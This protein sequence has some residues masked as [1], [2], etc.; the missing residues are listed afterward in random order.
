MTID[1]ATTTAPRTLRLSIGGDPLVADLYEPPQPTGE[2][3]VLLVHGWGGSGRY[4]AKTVQ[5]LRERFPLIVPDMPGIGRAMPVRRAHDMF[6][7]VA[8]L[9]ALCNELGIRKAHV[10]GH[11]M[12]GGVTIMLAARRPDLIER[13][14][15]T[16]IA[17]F[18]SDAQ[19]QLFSRVVDSAA[20]MMHLRGSWMADLP[21]LTNQAARTFFTRVP[22]EPELLRAAFRDYLT[23][24]R[25]SAVASARNATSPEIGRAA[26]HI[27]APTL[28]IVGSDDRYM[29]AENIASTVRS[30]PNCQARQI[31]RCGHLPMVEQPEA[32]AAL[33]QAF[34]TAP[35]AEAPG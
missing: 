33:L 8:A 14:V 6:G 16:S 11:S 35:G 10:V 30:I 20:L 12:G 17:L 5:R 23:M 24:D 34:L 28:L 22:D 1:H 27:Q 15:L 9:E 25:A 32:Y 31:E 29:P 13:L 21:G 26:A 19:R 7:Q 18:E 4:W 2:L 3:P